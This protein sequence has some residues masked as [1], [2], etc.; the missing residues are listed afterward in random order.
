MMEKIFK[1]IRENYFYCILLCGVFFLAFFIRWNN[2]KNYTT[3]WADDGGAHI[4]YVETLLQYHRFPTPRETYVAW[5]EPLYYVILAGWIKFGEFI[6]FGGLNWWE[7]LNTFFFICFLIL[8]WLI[9]YKYL[10]KNIWL[11]L[12]N[13]FLCSVVF[14]GVKLSAYINNEILAQVLILLLIFLF[15][16]LQLLEEKKYRQVFLWSMILSLATLTKLTAF[17]IFFSALILWFFYAA[18]RKKKFYIGY[19]LLCTVI[20]LFFNVPWFYYKQK[21]FGNVFTINIY[22]KKN[23]QNILKS[24]GWKYLLS[25]NPKIFFSAPYWR[26]EPDSFL[27]LLFADIFGDYYNLF[28]NVD[29]INNFPKEQKIFTGNGRSTTS[30]LWNAQT[31]VYRFSLIF[32]AVWFFGLLGYIYHFIT[33]KAV[34]HYFTFLLLVIFGGIFGLVY[35]NLRYPYLER[36][37]LKAGFI[38]YIY[39]VMTVV[40]FHYWERILKK[41]LI[42]FALFFITIVLYTVIAWPIL[43][44]DSL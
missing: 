14:V 1:A 6:G 19:A 43:I 36:G 2:L 34:Y 41:R 3:W 40:A 37:V 7:G 22:E 29:K 16:Q 5:H 10:K 17:I 35:N 28:N 13:V 44:I 8:V 9:S 25:V 4:V 18:F 23:A 27:S 15:L 31:R 21:T 32:A 12:L 39:P 38:M 11:A 30:V 20:L 33:K 26:T 42:W 24:D